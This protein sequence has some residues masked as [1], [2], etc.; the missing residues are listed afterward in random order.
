MKKNL[1]FFIYYISWVTCFS[2]D[3]RIKESDVFL[4]GIWIVTDSSNTEKF[5]DIWQLKDNGE[6]NQLKSGN[7]N[8]GRDTLVADE[9]GRWKLN[10][11][12]LTIT[13]TN[14]MSNGIRKQ[15]D[16]VQIMKFIVKADN[17]VFFLRIIDD[18]FRNKNK[19]ILN[20]ILTKK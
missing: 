8:Y 1:L 18:G 5:H 17:S 3:E 7:E 10:G 15:Y 4:V 16:K 19:T 12:T 20:L 13:V 14:E 9:N 11:D 2:Q 6:F